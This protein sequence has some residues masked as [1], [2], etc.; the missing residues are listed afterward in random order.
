MTRNISLICDLSIFLFTSCDLKGSCLLRK[1]RLGE[2]THRAL[3]NTSVPLLNWLPALDDGHGRREE[4][5]RNHQVGPSLEYIFCQMFGWK[6]T[7]W[8]QHIGILHLDCSEWIWLELASSTVG[9]AKSNPLGDVVLLKVDRNARS[10]TS[11]PSPCS[12]NVRH[13]SAR[14]LRHADG[15]ETQ[16]HGFW[17]LIHLERTQEVAVYKNSGG[18]T[19]PKK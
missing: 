18:H 7:L 13:E 12:N 5:V 9:K 11:S 16:N 14:I 15:T 19:C 3:L 10:K 8:E 1:Y 4:R 2:D 6:K 17:W